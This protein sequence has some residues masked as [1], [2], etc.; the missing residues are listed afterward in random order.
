MSSLII[1]QERAQL[2]FVALVRQDDEIP[3]VRAEI[4]FFERS[5]FRMDFKPTERLEPSLGGLQ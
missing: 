2:P 1:V 4:E 5:N 3:T